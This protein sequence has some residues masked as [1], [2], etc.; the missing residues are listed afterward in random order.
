MSKAQ[1]CRLYVI[2]ARAAPI[3]VIF[4]RGPS[5]WVQIV[6]WSTNTDTFEEGQWF[7]GRIYE[8]RCDLSPDGR[9]L[10]YFAQK[11]NKRTMRSDYTYA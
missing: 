5:R 3:A 4:R 1:S 6:K 9:L 2:L 10:V 7:H 8:R 11:I